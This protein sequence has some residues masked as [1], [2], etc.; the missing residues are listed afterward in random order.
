MAVA[1]GFVILAS[2]GVSLVLVMALASEA[3]L[4]T[5]LAATIAAGDAAAAAALFAEAISTLGGVAAAGSILGALGALLALLEKNNADPYFIRLNI[6]GVQMAVNLAPVQ[7]TRVTGGLITP[8]MLVSA[9]SAVTHTASRSRDIQ[10]IRRLQIGTRT[11][12]P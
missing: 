9:T 7:I 10:E 11:K 4:G 3:G 2:A 8:G 6:Q 1:I 5:A 12:P